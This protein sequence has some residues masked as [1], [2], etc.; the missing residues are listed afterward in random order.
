MKYKKRKN[1]FRRSRRKIIIV[2]MGSFL[3]LFASTLTAIYLT[4]YYELYQESQSMLAKYETL[5]Q[6]NGN[7]EE[8]SAKD[9]EL[10]PWKVDSP[11]INMRFILSSFYAVELD[12]YGNLV[13][14]DTGN[15]NLYSKETLTDIGQ[16][17]ATQKSEEGVSGNF[18][19]RIIQINENT[20]VT[21]MDNTLWS[22]SF[23][24]LFHNAFLIGSV[25]TVI[26]FFCSILVSGWIIRPLEENDRKQKQFISDASHE[27]KTPVS[28]VNAN[29][30]LLAREIGKNQWLE[31]IRYENNRMADLI[32]QLLTLART[33]HNGTTF[34]TVDLSRIVTGELLPFESTAFE[35]GFQI[36]SN[37][38]DSIYITGNQMQLTQMISIL[39]DN[40]IA[41]SCHPG[42]ITVSLKQNKGICTL[43]VTNPGFIPEAEREQIFSR[44]SR[45]ET[46]R[47]SRGNHYGLG[48][49]IVKNIVEN[50]R[51]RIMVSCENN[52]ITFSVLLP[53]K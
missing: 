21:L 40:A 15:H 41:H 13:S 10:P 52:S 7:P 45:R 49:A 17:L 3:L 42:I 34:E 27:L 36:E 9:L 16:K 35:Q 20:L 28:V 30:E 8:N 53:M 47:S 39:I 31:N 5:Y 38:Q 43:S 29:A 22:D 23:T 11:E 25:V 19:Y 51:G 44:F 6:K 2:L 26:L 46:E 4:S 18:I 50:H 37:L 33:E 1:T 48:L 14:I 32:N 24:T 12:P